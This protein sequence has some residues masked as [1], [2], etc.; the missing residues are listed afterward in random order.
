MKVFYKHIPIIFNMLGFLLIFLLYNG[1]QNIDAQPFKMLYLS[2]LIIFYLVLCFIFLQYIKRLH[3]YS[4]EDPLTG[5][6]NRRYLYTKLA[7]EM[8]NLK[9]NKNPL[10]LAIVDVD[11][12]K[13]INDTYGHLTGDTVLKEISNIF[14]AH[15]RSND[16]I[17][18]WGGDEFVFVLPNTDQNGAKK[19]ADRVRQVVEDHDFSFQVTISIGISCTISPIN[20][21]EFLGLADRALYKAKRNR[22]IVEIFQK[23]EDIELVV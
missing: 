19:F 22:N 8:M 13:N 20:V 16:T 11:N 5:L 3:S 4:F 21:E 23:I 17:A 14:K 18:V 7:G 9:K 6:A 15:T 12:F 10:S 2:T 1:Y